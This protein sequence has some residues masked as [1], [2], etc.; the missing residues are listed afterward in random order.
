[1]AIKILILG[2]L[3]NNPSHPYEMKQRL[4]QHGWDQIFSLTDGNLYHATR[5]LQKHEYIQA[6]KSEKNN[7]RPSRTIYQI[8]AAGFEHLQTSILEVFQQRRDEAKA[9]YPALL[10]IHLVPIEPVKQAIQ[11]W[12]EELEMVERQHNKLKGS[13]PELIADHYI[14]H[15][16]FQKNW[17]GRVQQ[18]LEEGKL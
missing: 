6:V 11:T 14:S 10:Y 1:M 5:Q 15:H 17:L 4:Q 16:Q 8:T 13:I 18:V 7:K 9:L 2:L 3:E 12:I